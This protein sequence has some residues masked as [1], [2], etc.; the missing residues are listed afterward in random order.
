LSNGDQRGR[1]NGQK[2][3]GPRIELP[4]NLAEEF[5][6]DIG[7]WSVLIDQVFPGAKT[8]N[9]IALAL[10]Y[11]KM[12][13]LQ[14][15]KKPV[16]IVPVW[17]SALGYEVE[18]VWPGIGELLTTAH[19][20]KAFAGISRVE[21]GPM[22]TRKFTANIRI[23]GGNANKDVEVTFP[24]Y[25]Q[26]TV[27][28][29]VGGQVC[30]FEGP[31]V[32]YLEAFGQVQGKDLPNN[33]W[34]RRPHGQLAKCAKAAALRDAFPEDIPADY[35]IPE[36]IRGA[37]VDGEASVVRSDLPQ[38]EDTRDRDVQVGGFDPKT[39][40]IKEKAP[41]ARKGATTKR[42][43]A[44]KPA[45]TKQPAKAAEPERQQPAKADPGADGPPAGN[46]PPAEAY[47]SQPGPNIQ[48][49]DEKKAGKAGADQDGPPD[50]QKPAGARRRRPPS[51][52]VAN[53][54]GG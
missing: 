39:G 25:A 49:P 44:T 14:I 12:R 33:M 27:Y 24:E 38:I 34:A 36:E 9:A 16:H 54:F 8:A 47:E 45:E 40:E 17:N 48:Q 4:A 15:Y 26:Q 28:R 51:E 3:T 2:S 7:S 13:G 35:Y 41:T 10:R 42:A 6:L 5:G 52:G 30:A 31:E 19:R 53:L 37:V 20:T 43:A 22:I 21:W 29:L 23:K 18:T 11:C 1:G 50:D 32:Y 46:E